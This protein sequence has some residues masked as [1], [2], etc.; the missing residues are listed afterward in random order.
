MEIS[1]LIGIWII[2]SILLG[3]E[4]LA[5]RGTLNQ[6]FLLHSWLPYCQKLSLLRQKI[7][8]FLVFLISQKDEIKSK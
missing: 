1:F 8:F 4:S 7:A 3:N 6:F 2:G 5:N